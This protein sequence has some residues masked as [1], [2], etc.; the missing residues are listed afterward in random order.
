MMTLRLAISSLMVVF[1]FSTACLAE[2]DEIILGWTGPLTGNSAVLGVDSVVAAQMAVDELNASGGIKGRKVKLVVEDDQHVTAK[3]VSAYS[4]LTTKDKAAAILMSTYGGY[5]AAAERAARDGVIIMNP[6]DCNN[7]IAKLPD[8]AFCLATETESIG[9]IIADHIIDQKKHPIA[10]LYDQTHPF[11]L[12][13]QKT[14]VKRLKK[15]GQKVSSS[16]G[17]APDASEFKS[18]LL[19]IKKQPQE[20]KSLILL[21]HDPMGQAMREARSLGVNA[22]FYTVGTITSPGFQELAGD[23]ANGTFVAFWEAPKSKR[24]DEFVSAFAKRVG[25][26]P[27]LELA[28]IP[29][30]DS[31]VVL[32]DSIKNALNE[33]GKIDT[34][35]MK[36]ALLKVENMQGL[37]G[38]IT[39]EPDG[40]VRTIKE[41]IYQFN[42]G[43]LNLSKWKGNS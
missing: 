11:M 30:Y 10:M 38:T 15:Y 4:K 41:K 12:L 27:I 6:L 35:K 23:A 16:L 40:V 5:F 17:Y 22:Q 20:V 43:K 7:E 33:E 25:R 36:Q 32:L 31:T 26:P 14:I 34:E 3:T 2:R 29:S 37:S 1:L 9:N 42:A 24:Y 39:I 21:G 13:V 19:K 18:H 28:T 8:N